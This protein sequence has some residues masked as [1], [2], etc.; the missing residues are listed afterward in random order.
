MF[1]ENAQNPLARKQ[2]EEAE[3]ENFES[4][5]MRN[6]DNQRERVERRYSNSV[7]SATAV[8]QPN[9]CEEV[10]NPQ[11]QESQKM[12]CEYDAALER[13]DEIDNNYP[14]G[15]VNNRSEF[16]HGHIG[17]QIFQ[18]QY[19]QYQSHGGFHQQRPNFSEPPMWPN[20]HHPAPPHYGPGLV[21]NQDRYGTMSRQMPFAA[22]PYN[23]GPSYA[24]PYGQPLNPAPSNKKAELINL[25]SNFLQQ[26]DK[27]H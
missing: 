5:Q 7:H 13:L 19:P 11:F 18:E 9:F 17:N 15:Y 4:R 21:S 10:L 1:G 25:F 2:N 27:K 26:I 12:D 3:N 16:S 6:I 8:I 14:A 20:Y 24:P 23:N 22:N